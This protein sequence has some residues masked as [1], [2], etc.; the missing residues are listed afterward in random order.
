MFSLPPNARSFG[1]R[2]LTRYAL[3]LFATLAVIALRWA[4]DPYL[5][6]TVPYISVFPAIIFSAW[7]CG[8]G[9]S[10][11]SALTALVAE[12]YLFSRPRYSFG[13]GSANEGVQIG[14]YLLVAGFV[15]V[16]AEI[17]RRSIRRLDAANA[18]LESR[19]QERT[20]EL[21]RQAAE[22][23]SRSEL[24]DMANDAV[25]ATQE[26]RITYWNR[27][28]ERL[29]GWTREEAKG[30][31]P[32]ELLRSRLP[33]AR[34]EIVAQVTREG[35]WEGDI[36]QVRRDGAQIAVASHWSVWRDEQGNNIGWLEINT[37]ITQRKRAEESLRELT[38]RLLRLQDEE[39]RRIARELHDSTGQMLVAL[40][41]N[42]SAMEAEDGLSPHAA[43]V[44]VDSQQLVQE[45]TREVRTLSYLLHP[46]L[47]DEAGLNSAL[48]W[49]VEGFSKRSHVIVNLEVNSEI[50]RL[51]R[52]TEMAIF[53]IVQECLTNVHRHSGSTFAEIRVERGPDSVRVEVQDEGRG[54]PPEK[55]GNPKSTGGLGIGITGM[56]ERVRQLGGSLQI[57]SNEGGTLIRAE[58]PAPL[59]AVQAGAADSGGPSPT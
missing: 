43:K 9:P 19:V 16:M 54:I 50:G 37:D 53:R 27:G 41:I 30:K 1:W 22:L 2:P 36:T 13:V 40:G 52:E 45:M 49:Y 12:N 47:L 33:V 6:D 11:L 35:S 59:G 28:A 42:L 34:D 39:R 4:L 48:R 3:A 25:F 21:R 8:L 46:P 20:A 7:Y 18:T 24:L 44:L 38:G 23:A 29:Y 10:L 51:P 58:L 57:I 32:G 14:I 56:R 5:G 15:V 26:G 55:F 31:E 17:N